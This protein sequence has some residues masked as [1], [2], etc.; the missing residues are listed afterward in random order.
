MYVG[1]CASACVCCF[2]CTFL[3]A[4]AHQISVPPDR[5]N[6]LVTFA[7]DVTP[8]RIVVASSDLTSRII[9]TPRYLQSSPLS[10]LIQES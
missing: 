9:T 4:C 8:F 2:P 3:L 7:T 6:R 5:V 1:Y 10:S